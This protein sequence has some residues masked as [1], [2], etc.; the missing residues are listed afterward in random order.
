MYPGDINLYLLHPV[1]PFWEQRKKVGDFQLKVFIPISVIRCTTCILTQIVKR[2]S[3][4][5]KKKKDNK[6]VLFGMVQLVG[7]PI[8]FFLKGEE[9]HLP[10]ILKRFIEA[11]LIGG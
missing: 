7:I 2:D 3:R 9:C 1:P 5:G 10:G 11:Y 8:L 4:Q 6:G